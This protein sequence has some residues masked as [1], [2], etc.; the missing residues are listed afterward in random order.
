[1]AVVLNSLLCFLVNKFGKFGNRLLKDAIIEFYSCDI[2]AEAK[3]KLLADLVSLKPNVPLPHVPSRRGDDRRAPEVADIFELPSFADE[4]SL[5]KNL[6]TYVVND[7]DS[8]P[9]MRLFE[10]DVRLLMSRIDKIEGKMA[11]VSTHMTAMSACMASVQRSLRELTAVR[12]TTAQAAAVNFVAKPT[13]P[14][15]VPAVIPGSLTLAPAIPLISSAVTTATDHYQLSASTATA[16]ADPSSQSW[17]ERFTSGAEVVGS[18]QPQLSCY[19]LLSSQVDR[20]CFTD[21]EATATDEDGDR[22]PFQTVTHRRKRP[23]PTSGADGNNNRYNGTQVNN[24]ARSKGKGKSLLMM[25]RKATDGRETHSRPIT[26]VKPH[27]VRKTVLCIDNVSSAVSIGDMADFIRGELDVDILSIYEAKSRRRRND[28]NYEDRKAFRLCINECDVDR[29][30]LADMWPENITISEWFFKGKRD[31]A[32]ID[33]RAKGAVNN[34]TNTA[35]VHLSSAEA[36]SI[37]NTLNRFFGTTADSHALVANSG[38]D[39]ALPPQRQDDVIGS[40]GGGERVLSSSPCDASQIDGDATV[41]AMDS[42]SILTSDETIV[43]P[44]DCP[45]NLTNG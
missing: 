4:Q 9:N 39:K 6:P 10:G 14:S 45:L 8:V 43:E 29:L 24:S 35:D 41:V 44:S 33:N 11:D 42:S 20:N 25:G 26:A 3:S 31:G 13:A 18:Q 34:A 17:A 32:P 27:I 5:L 38:V 40:I 12:Q 28:S 7:L 37:R 30:L 16:S 15:T 2:V 19:S 36:H 1:M 23:R 21:T 22:R